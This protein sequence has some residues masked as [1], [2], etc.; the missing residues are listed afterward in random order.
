L[1]HFHN[2]HH[3]RPVAAWV[4]AT[5]PRYLADLTRY[6]PSLYTRDS[7]GNWYPDYLYWWLDEG[8]GLPLVASVGGQNAG[9][10]FLN[11]TPQFRNLR[12]DLKLSEFFVAPE[13]RRQKVGWR[14]VQRLAEIY[15][16]VWEVEAIHANLPAVRF[17]QGFIA[18]HGR[19]LET[20]ESEAHF[21]WVFEIQNAFN[22]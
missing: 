18:A 7:A 11:L 9:F 19:L 14:I 1:L 5:Y 10:V 4:R 8:N 20:T 15:G 6:E 3:A 2:A 16:G 12:A 13:F 17:W 22:V 21:N